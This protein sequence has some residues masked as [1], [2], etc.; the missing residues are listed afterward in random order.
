MNE[1]Q[2]FCKVFK[3]LEMR[4]FVITYLNTEKTHSLEYEETGVANTRSST[5][6]KKR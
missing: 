4:F 6:D 1:L 5:V 3:L 2:L